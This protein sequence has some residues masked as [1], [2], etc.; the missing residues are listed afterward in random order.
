MRKSPATGCDV[1]AEEVFENRKLREK[2]ELLVDRDD[3]GGDGLGRRPEGHGRAKIFD[4]AR[5][6]PVRPD[7]DPDKRT[8]PCPVLAQQRMDTPRHQVQVDSV[9]RPR[10]SIRF[11]HALNTV[12]RRRAFCPLRCLS[13][14]GNG[15]NRHGAPYPT[16]RINV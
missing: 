15:V 8:F 7:E 9:E 11:G 1:E 2:A 12:N 5:G 13:V 16:A 10:R 6:R 14:G 3:P 4:D